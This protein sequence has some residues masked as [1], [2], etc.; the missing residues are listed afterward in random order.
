M[1]M[2]YREYIK[3]ALK[4]LK[5]NKGRTILTMLGMFIGVGAV[6]MILSLGEGF[7]K[8]TSNFYEDIG[9]GS[10]YVYGKV[11]ASDALLT[12]EDIEA[13]KLMP[14]IETVMGGL[15]YY[16]STYDKKGNTKSVIVFGA[17][18]EYTQYVEKITLLAGRNLT[19][20]DE[21]RKAHAIVVTDVFAKVILNQK[22]YK[23]IIGDTVDI[24]VGGQTT[25][26]EIVG[27]YDSKMPSN[28]PEEYLEHALKTNHYIPY[29]TLNLLLG[30][31]GKVEAIYG[32]IKDDADPAQAAT[33]I[34]TF[35]NR[36]HHQKDGYNVQTAISIIDTMNEMMSI[37]TIFISAVAGIS[38]IVGGVGIMNIMLVT[39]KERTREIGVRK[40]LG[41]TNKDILSQFLIEALMLTV[42]A[43]LI[44]M[45]IGYLG[46]LIV[47]SKYNIPIQLTLG[48]I[49]FSAGISI[50]I[51]ILFGV[52]PAYQAA[53]LDPV[54]SLRYE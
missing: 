7:K 35:L 29:S 42:I 18:P 48:M 50:A 19:I 5:S 52:Y 41:A 30:T 14:E 3:S 43:G 15:S 12:Q 20:E 39:V 54:E 22:N 25:S 45:A 34:R 17:P 10:F 32:T 33:N 24:T 47:G 38:L 23:D 31:E 2:N 8:Y 16:G 44:G 1:T 37:I 53:K 49:L 46:A 4:Q 11:T 9:L 36:R 6:I 13:L 40:A 51:G 28:V 21:E 27:V 26:F